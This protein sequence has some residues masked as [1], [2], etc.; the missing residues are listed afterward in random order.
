M[1][2][3]Y[4]EQPRSQL[5]LNDYLQLQAL[6][7]QEQAEREHRLLQEYKKEQERRRI[8]KAMHK[9]QVMTE[10]YRRREQEELAIQAY[11]AAKKEQEQRRRQQQLI[12]QEHKKRLLLQRQRQQQQ[13][14]FAALQQRQQ[15]EEQWN[16]MALVAQQQQQQQKSAEYAN[17]LHALATAAAAARCE[18]TIEEES[19]SE[20]EAEEETSRQ[21]Q[22]DALVK[23]IFG[24]QNDEAPEKCEKAEQKQPEQKL[25][26]QKQPEQKQPEQ[27]QPEQKQPEQK[28]P[29]Q[30]QEEQYAT[31]MNLDQFVDYISQR[32]QALDDEDSEEEEVD[33][34]EEDMEED[35]AMLA[36]EHID[37]NES[38]DED[39]FEHIENEQDLLAVAAEHLEDDEEDVPAL[40]E[41]THD[42]QELVNEILTNEDH[43]DDELSQ[44]PTEDPVKIA[45]YDALHRIESELNEIRQSHEDKVLHAVLDFSDALN[46]ER[47]ASPEHSLITATTSANREF[48]GYE[49]Q[50]MK[51][52]L[53]LDMIQSNGDK[54]IRNER[55]ALV[56]MAEEMLDK[57][58]E[59]K[60]REW[61]RVSC[62][63]HSE[64]EDMYM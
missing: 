44:F 27:K 58:D 6:L 28:Q 36:I 63:S 9:L 32:V 39:D 2:P 3:I 54:E 10:L 34:Q 64:D 49:D 19:E 7:R 11:Y 30:K 38:M 51:A 25:P 14:Y 33:D 35:T 50:I 37:D 55:K 48:L 60:Q 61:E 12:E 57:L 31:A 24:A 18:D 42:I 4:I 56:R 29:E 46:N 62:S 59:F 17:P 15:L 40:V 43:E 5:S 26:E 53:K 23:L 52:L 16:L 13:E 45:K 21:I 1:Y 22:L 47:A 41:S 8:E 20:T